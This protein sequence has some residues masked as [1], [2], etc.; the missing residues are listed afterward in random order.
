M[1]TPSRARPSSSS[2]G[3]RNK[4]AR[5]ALLER[6]QRLPHDRRL[7][8]RPAQPAAHLAIRRDERGRALLPG[9][10]RAPPHDGRQHERLSSPGELR[11]E[12]EDLRLQAG[13]ARLRL[14]QRL[15]DLRGRDRHVDVLHAGVPQRVDH[16][17]DVRGGGAD[18]RR[19]AD[20]LRADRV[21]RRRRH[22]LAQLE[23]R[24]LPRR[25]DQV[26]HEV[27]ADRV[28]DLVERDQLHR[29]GGV[30]LREAARD[31]PLDDHRVDPHAA[32]VD[33][34]H[35]ANLPHARV[36]VDLDRDDVRPERERQVRR[37]VVVDALEPGLHALR[38]VRVRRE[39]HVLDRLDLIG[40]AADGELPGLV[41]DVLLGHL[42]QVRR[43]L[44]RLLADA[45]GD[46]RRRRAGRGRGPRGVRAEAVRRVVR[47]AVH[48]L[49]VLR[50][51]PELA[52]DDLGERR[53]V[54]L[55]L[56]LAAELEDRLAGRMDPKLGA[57]VHLHADDVVVL[58]R[59][60]ADDLGERRDADAV[61]LALR[62]SVGLLLPKVVV[63][64]HL[65]RLVHGALVVAAVVD[66]PRRGRV[67]EL[68]RL[69]EVLLPDVDGVHAQLVRGVLHQAL[70]QV[71]RLGHA[72]RAPVRDAPGR[73]V[74]VGAFRR[75]VGR[76]QVVRAA[77]DVEQA[78]LE[79][80]G[81]GVGEERALVGQQR[82]PQSEHGAVALERERSGHVVVAGEPGGDEVLGTLLDPLHR[83]P[84]QERRG[85]GHDV[86]GV[87][88]HLVAEAAADVGRHDPDLLL[89]QA[90]DEREH[91]A[92][93]VR[94]LR[95]HVDRHLA[96]RGA[97]VRDASA[98]LER[99]RVDRG[100]RTC[101]ARRRRRPVRTRRPSP[102]CRRPPTSR[103]GC[104]PGLPCRSG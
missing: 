59:S 93:R 75:D 83:V 24:R 72:E 28:A 37:V 98:R 90:R 20:A 18:R 34:D 63:P 68:V 66:E 88:R 38:V 80:R 23:L 92:D 40:R 31:L 89:R 82:C 71:R 53:L 86:A 5:R 102:P 48:D 50:L 36:G 64:D 84:Q 60:G 87:H 100:G 97:D 79:L 81:L 1:T 29:R 2:G 65:E 101:R 11:R 7:G 104:S 27:R 17:V 3:P 42:E 51:D 55:P 41:L 95:R 21:M 67:R 43:E 85:R 4:Q 45:A 62:A 99:R 96:G 8:A 33:G 12:L 76:R 15:P 70:D 16:R 94:R 6:L 57:V 61:E 35:P 39:R 14:L 56:R 19:L 78:G 25:R 13:D 9:R 47:V 91:R 73:L 46:H 26:V 44:H 30:A 10:R 54:P 103:R 32:V 52:G 58:R 49:D 77:H 74:R 69:D 22:G